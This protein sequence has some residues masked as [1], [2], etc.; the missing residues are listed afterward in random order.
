[1]DLTSGIITPI[2][3]YTAQLAFMGINGMLIQYTM[4]PLKTIFPMILSLS[5][6]NY[7]PTPHVYT[8]QVLCRMENLKPGALIVFVLLSIPIRLRFHL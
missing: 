2:T 7:A 6:M 1:M 4:L 8:V 5:N 3:E